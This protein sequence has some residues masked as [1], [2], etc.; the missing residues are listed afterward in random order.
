MS[1]SRRTQHESEPNALSLAVRARRAAGLSLCDLT[2]SNPTLTD[3]PYERARLLAAL[4]DARSLVYEP[5]SFGLLAARRA[6]QELQRE[7]GFEIPSDRIVLTSSTSEAYGFL[8]KLLCDAGDEVLIPQPSY[9]LFEHL[10]AL[11]QVKVANYEL[12]YDGAWHIDFD[13]LER[14][15]SARTRAIVVV[16]PNN[17]TGS[18]L[19]RDELRR[20]LEFG[21]PIISDEVFSS[22][23]LGPD[24]RRVSSVLETD[25]AL[26]FALGGLSKLAALPQL[27]L[28]W[29]CAAGP[30]VELAEALSR[31]E[32]IAD[33]FLSPNTPVQHALPEILSSRVP[34]ER[35][36]NARIARNFALLRRALEG[37]AVTPLFLEGGWY[38]VVRLPELLSEAE[39]V[40]ALLEQDGVLTQPGWFYD[41]S[42][43]AQL[44]LSLITEDAP[45]ALGVTRIAERVAKVVG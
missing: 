22:F 44:V 20:L 4:S 43:G 14:A 38:A 10:A 17:P 11:E 6:V 25:A 27:K 12:A 16:N 2:Q 15:R 42:R 40:L 9:P 7:A 13:S 35:A 5:D 29:L 32:L 31:L 26:V 41:F 30:R 39:W 8:F 28:A 34:V 1:F 23:A 24:P 37:T 33:T 21:L 18:F 45:F 3:L 36:L 19:K